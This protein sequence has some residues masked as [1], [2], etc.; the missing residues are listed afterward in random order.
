MTHYWHVLFDWNT[1][2]SVRAV[3][4]FF[5]GLAI[6]FFALLVLFDILAHQSE[7]KNNVLP[8]GAQPSTLLFS[9]LYAYFPEMA[10]KISII[11]SFSFGSFHTISRIMSSD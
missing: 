4:S 8:R 6:A 2:E 11:V 5:E 7:D 3:H 1:L 9:T 10:F